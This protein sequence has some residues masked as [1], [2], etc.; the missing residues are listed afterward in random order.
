MSRRLVDSE[1]W[2]PGINL[3][4]IGAW[5][6]RKPSLLSDFRDVAQLKVSLW[7]GPKAGVLRVTWAE[8]APLGAQIQV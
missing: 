6:R 8:A 5:V 1:V 3:P 7:S 4:Y 2:G